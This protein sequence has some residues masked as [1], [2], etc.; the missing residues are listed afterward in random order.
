[1][2]PLE[3]LNRLEGDNKPSD[4]ELNSAA[5]E[6]R[7]ALDA[8]TSIEDPSVD[9]VKL[10]KNLKAALD[11]LTQEAAAREDERAAR[12][13][14]A[15]ALREG[16]FEEKADADKDKDAGKDADADADKAPEADADA[17]ADEPADADKEP[18]SA[19]A[20]SQILA[21]LRTTAAARTKVKE[22]RTV[23]G[24]SIKPMGPAAGFNI[25]DGSFADLG[26]M[27][28]THAKS[29]SG[30]GKSDRLF[31]LSK[32]YSTDRVLG[33]SLDQNN[34]RLADVF[35]FGEQSRPVTAAGGLCGPGDVDHSHPICA[36][37]GRPVRDSL[38]QFNASR[39][40]VTYTPSAGLGD[41]D[42]A[43][44]RWTAQMDA[45]AATPA[46]S[47]LFK[48]CPPVTC[49][50]EITAQVDAITRCLTIGNFQAKFSPELWASR[51]ELLLA[52]HDR[53][54]E[55]KA[56][57][58]IHEA[59]VA[60]T[61][62]ASSNII[63]SFLQNINSIVA[64]DRAI[65]RKLTGSY[66]VLADM[67]VR[68]QI[69]NQ[70]I[71]NLGVAN[72]VET[73]QIA[74]SIIAGWLSDIGVRAVWTPDGTVSEATGDHN[75]PAAVGA[76]PATTTVYVYPDDAYFFLDGGTIDLGTSITDSSLN[77][78][79]DRQ[80][81]AETFEKVAF[82]GCSSYRFDLNTAVLCGCAP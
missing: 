1:M 45:D 43:V 74:D 23:P 62:I 32:E 77:A 61:A 11:K 64:S 56:I 59:S 26:Q 10:A 73:L 2:D 4:S 12:R 52:L 69:R 48:P 31:T 46:G 5:L 34:K 71:E 75:I 57:E 18:V 50:E 22:T 27:F 60:V 72:N 7:E 40:Q 13:A 39:G 33:A 79:N 70:V 28:A 76:L 9:D 55:Q 8:A 3:I 38:P 21:N 20:V 65:Q 44:S 78:T 29:I 58:E 6:I 16:V 63:E 66:V 30:V 17:K 51:L 41:V 35:G 54:A 68:D 67:W 19:S 49:P 15:K 81:F 42:G 53:E 14:E 37:R 25:G 80:A 24:V 36:D 82:R 47:A